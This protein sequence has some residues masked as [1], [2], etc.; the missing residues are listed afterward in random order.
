MIAALLRWLGR[1][2][3]M[4]IP[5]LLWQA[6]LARHDFL[7]A[8]PPDEREQLKALCEAFLHEKEFSGAHGFALSDKIC[9]AIAAQACLP[10]LHLGLPAYRD[11]VGIVIYPDEFVVSRSIEDE[12]G[13]VH[14][15]DD[16]LAG[17]AMPGGPVVLSWRDVAETDGDYNVVIHEFAHKLDM[18][19]GEA[20][21]VPPLPPEIARREWESCLMAAYDDF[22]ARVD[23]GE[24]TR[25]DPY[26]AEHP[27]EFFAVSSEV[28]FGAPAVLAADYPD[29]YALLCRYYRQDPLARSRAA[30]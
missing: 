8:L 13:V 19:N 2:P 11:W 4:R 30:N 25:I 22:C 14:E 1:R 24:E 29:F 15:F 20:D 27:S 6:T 18:Q 10:I 9:V 23:G 28:F 3:P 16:I 26:A 7:R 5:P 17:E 21:G 12:D